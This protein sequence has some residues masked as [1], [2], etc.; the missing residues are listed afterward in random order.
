MLI[1][2]PRKNFE[3]AGLYASGIQRNIEF[4]SFL[5]WRQ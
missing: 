3:Q 5:A 1:V 4:A 2:K